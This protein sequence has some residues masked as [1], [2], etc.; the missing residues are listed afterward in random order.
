MFPGSN[1]TLLTKTKTGQL[2]PTGDS[3][4]TVIED[5]D[6]CR[7]LLGQLREKTVGTLGGKKRGHMVYVIKHTEN[8][9]IMK[10][11]RKQIN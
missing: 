3:L 9:P 4:L 7:Y 10:R 6:Y 1:K 5:M 8:N 11:K 2:W